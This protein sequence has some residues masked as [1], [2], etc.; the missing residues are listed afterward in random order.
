MNFAIYV[1]PQASSGKVPVLYWLSGLTCTEANFTAKAGCQRIASEHGI[2]VVAP[3]TSP[4]NCD[5]EGEEESWDFG[6]GAGFYVDATEEKWK[7]HYR[8]YSYI[9][10]ELPALVN[11]NFPALEGQMSVFGHS[12]GGHGALIAFL[13]NPGLYKSVSAFAPICNPMNCPWGQKAFGGYLGSNK[14]SWKGYDACEL[15][16]A[17]KGPKPEILIDQGLGDKFYDAQQLLPETFKK[18]CEEV[19]HPLNLR[20]HEEYDHSY[21]FIS[22]FLEDHVKHHVKYLER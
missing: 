6:T 15:M 9:T 3:D 16:K 8:M 21:Y 12:M 20:L 4:R 22:T 1:P 7:K 18:A 11:A 13:K 14:E 17:Y 10:K 19:T 5:I 2:I